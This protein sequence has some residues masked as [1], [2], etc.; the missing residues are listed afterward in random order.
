M[1]VQAGW[2][3]LTKSN[4][5]QG[6]AMTDAAENGKRRH[7][8]PDE[9]LRIA[10][11]RF[12]ICNYVFRAGAVW[13]VILILAAVGMNFVHDPDASVTLLMLIFA[14]ATT[15]MIGFALTCAI[16][17]CPVCDQYLSRF[18]PD[19]LRCPRCNVQVKE[20]R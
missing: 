7:L 1:L 6:R 2:S 11:W 16:Y 13:S 14:F 19:K 15:N 12:R 4:R 20:A 10:K 8:D 9:V 18:R 5:R 3:E 17:R